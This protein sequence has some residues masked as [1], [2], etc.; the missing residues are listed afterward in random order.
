MRCWRGSSATS[1]PSRSAIRPPP[2]SARTGS[3]WSPITPAPPAAMTTAAWT[4]AA[5]AWSSLD[6]RFDEA[7]ARWREAAAALA[8]GGASTASAREALRTA[9]RLACGMGARPLDRRDRGACLPRPHPAR[10][11]G[12]CAGEGPGAARTRDAD[13]ARARGPRPIGRRTQQRRDRRAPL[14]QPQ[15]GI[16]ACRRTSRTSSAFENRVEAA[17][18]A[19]RLGIAPDEDLETKA[20]RTEI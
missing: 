9:H 16:G 12:R 2:I 5:A 8:A 1:P 7:V 17:T 13:G 3:R 15:D 10:A 19:T 4:A 20:P 11:A 6:H 18:L 14:H